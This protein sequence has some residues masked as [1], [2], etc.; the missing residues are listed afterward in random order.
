VRS[1]RSVGYRVADRVR[2]VYW[3]VRRPQTFG[4]KCIIERDGKWLMIR[5]SYGRRHWTFPGGGVERGESAEAAVRREVREEVGI[6]LSEVHEIGTYR[7]MT[8]RRDTVTCFRATVDSPAFEIDP[9][10]IAEARWIDSG[11]VPESRSPAVEHIRTM[12]ADLS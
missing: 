3:F 4:V 9:G 7:G 10:E 12:L 8:H 11:D 1:W 2:R 6:A 5:N